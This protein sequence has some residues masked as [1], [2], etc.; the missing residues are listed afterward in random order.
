MLY[1]LENG[2]KINIPDNEL[3]KNMEKLELSLDDAI[4]LWLTDNDYEIDEEQ[5]ELNEKAKKVKIQHDAIGTETRKKS[6]KPRTVKV[7]DA[8]KELF[9]NINAFLDLFAINKGAKYKILT[10]NK[11]FQVEFGGET[12]KIDLVQQR[13]PKK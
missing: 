1:T 2:K 11:L 3:Q 5:E 10:E 12:F 7:S 8:K 4:D 9:N 13:K 6:E